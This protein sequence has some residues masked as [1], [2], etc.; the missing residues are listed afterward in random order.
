MSRGYTL[1]CRAFTV[2]VTTDAG[3]RIIEASSR[4]RRFVGDPLE[5]L[6]RWMRK[7]GG[8][9]MTPGTPNLFTDAVEATD[10]AGKDGA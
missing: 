2:E 9:R 1:A 3:G 6:A 5:S 7:F 8:F 4:A 10:S